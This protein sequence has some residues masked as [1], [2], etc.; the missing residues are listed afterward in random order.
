MRTGI[1]SGVGTTEEVNG[2]EE[3]QTLD[4]RGHGNTA[5]FERTMVQLRSEM[6]RNQL[7]VIHYTIC[8]YA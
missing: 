7:S 8:Y 4:V 1:H 6:V 3:G 5:K 2:A